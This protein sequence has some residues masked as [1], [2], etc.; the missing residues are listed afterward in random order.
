[1]SYLTEHDPLQNLKLGDLLQAI[2]KTFNG[3]TKKFN[4]QVILNETR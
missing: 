1:M 3:H 2:K 4:F